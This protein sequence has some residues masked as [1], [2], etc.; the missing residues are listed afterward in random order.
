METT[1]DGINN[2][3]AHEQLIEQGLDEQDQVN[4]DLDHFSNKV[5]LNLAF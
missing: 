2:L 5:F 4:Y 3:I 1:N